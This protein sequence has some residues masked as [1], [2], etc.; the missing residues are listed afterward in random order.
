MSKELK[1][2]IDS[3]E[4]ETQSHA[5]LEKTLESIKEEKNRLEFVVQEQATLIENFKSLMKDEDIEQAKLPSEIDVLKDIISSQRE[6]LENKQNIINGFDNKIF[7]ISSELESNEDFDVGEKLNEEFINAQKL[8]IQLTEENEQ[9]K[10]QIERLH[11]QLSEIQSE[12]SEDEDWLYENTQTKENEELINFKKLNFQL[13]EENGLLRVEIESLKSKFQEKLDELKSE[14]ME[15]VNEK[16]ANLLSELE[17]LKERFQ[18]HIETSSE[19]L[20]V[21]NGTIA[22]L[23]SELAGYEAQ[24]RSLQEQLEESSESAVMTT[25]EVLQFNEMKEELDDVKSKL[26]ESQKDNQALNEELSELKQK[27]SG[28]ETEK[29][30]IGQNLPK[31]LHISLFYRMYGLLDENKKLEV[32]NS[33]IQDLQSDNSETK[34]NAIRILSVIKNDKV[35]DAFIQ[36]LDDVDWLVRYSIIKALSKFEKKS[37]ELKPILKNLSKD[38]DVDVRELAIRILDDLSL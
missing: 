28:K 14:E 33:L 2:L 20:E 29:I 37:E 22:M 17:S 13:M 23:T 9:Y 30:E 12:G 16:N 38:L 27:L 34:R 8:I 7:E 32:I 5:E 19:E 35:Y 21:A 31:R 11:N 10:D 6:E 4:K 18:E 3:V 26:L 24:V 15:S 1:D 36:M 25:E